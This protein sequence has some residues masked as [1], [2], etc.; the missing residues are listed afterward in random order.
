MANTFMGA[1]TE[2]LRT[3]PQAIRTG[4]DALGEAKTSVSR[5]ARSEEIWRGGDAD[6]FRGHIY[7]SVL[8]ALDSIE[9]SLDRLADDAD[10]HAEE[11]DLASDPG[12][13]LD[14]VL[15]MQPLPAPRPE[16]AP[17]AGR[18]AGRE[19]GRRD[20]DNDAGPAQGTLGDGLPDGL[21][22]P[23]PGTTVPDPG[24]PEWHP[25][26]AGAGDWGSE[27]PTLGDQANHEAA[28]QMASLMSVLWPDASENLL[29]FLGN[30]GADKEMD[31]EAFLADEPDIRSQIE[32]R[33][34]DIGQLALER[35][36]QSG[37]DGPV[38]FPVQT[39]WPG[40]TA[41]SDNWY[42]ATGSGNYSMNGQVTVYPPDATNPEWRYEMNTTLNYRDQYN[43]DGSKSTT[44]DLPGPVDPT[45]SDE[46]LAELHRAGL[47]KE[48][49]LHGTSERRTTGP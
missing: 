43:W 27:D 20:G 25:V 36:Q 35:A 16:T 2:A 13:T 31:L 18:E 6:D 3:F 22:T 47:A 46:Q 19:D 12:G 21:G 1:D 5:G 14:A 15:F 48:F 42:Y 7:S 28:T 32:T 10:G 44:I 11:Q 41:S 8:P 33:E 29:H 39:G 9:R 4:R 49:L 34:R 38:T 37:A 24:M 23:V 40:T 30:S 17:R 26:D 45:I